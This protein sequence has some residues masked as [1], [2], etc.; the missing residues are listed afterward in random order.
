MITLSKTLGL[1]LVVSLGLTFSGCGDKPEDAKSA[2]SEEKHTPL[3]LFVVQAES[4]TITQL[5][6]K[7]ADSST[8]QAEKKYTLTLTHTDKDHVIAFTDRPDRL[9]KYETAKKLEADGT[10][11]NDSFKK[12][13]PNAVLSSAGIKHPV[14]VVLDSMNSDG[15]TTTFTLHSAK[16]NPTD[17][18]LSALVTNKQALANVVVT[19]NGMRYSD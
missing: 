12:N 18:V 5:T 16:H 4:G 8:E 7:E 1:A 9:V 10:K 2:A 13:P 6:E 3:W 19:I 17:V 14:I 11:G 15:T